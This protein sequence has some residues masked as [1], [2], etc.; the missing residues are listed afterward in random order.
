MRL[1]LNAIWFV[2][3]GVW[4]AI[5][6]VLVSLGLLLSLI[7]IP[8]AWQSLKIAEFALWPFGR[9]LVKRPQPA[10]PELNAIGNVVWIVLAGWWLALVHL[11]VGVLLIVTVI[12]IPLG[13][14]VFKMIPITFAPFGREVVRLHAGGPGP[15][16]HAFAL[17]QRW[18]LRGS[19]FPRPV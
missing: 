6:W 15:V 14:G 2:F 17:P 3:A 8:F 7:G 12:G 5:L 13:L 10:A 4:L 1:A 16:R 18:Q 19:G 11:I 9:A